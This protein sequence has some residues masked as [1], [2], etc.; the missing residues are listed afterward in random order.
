MAFFKNSFRFWFLLHICFFSLSGK[1][2]DM[3]KDVA[4]DNARRAVATLDYI[5]G[6]YYEAVA[7]E[8]GKII[9]D[10]EYQEMIR[11]ISIVQKYVKSLGI[12]EEEPLK[13]YL[14]ELN[15]FILNKAPPPGV[16]NLARDA[17]QE[18]IKIFSIPT[19]PVQ[20]PDIQLGKRLYGQACASCHGLDG[21]AE[22]PSSK[23][24]DP[25]P[26]V[27]A[28]V[29]T[30]NNLS[31][32]K[33]FNTVTF[34]I[35]GTAMAAFPMFSESERWAIASY[36]FTFRPDLPPATDDLASP[37]I[38]WQIAMRLTDGEILKRLKRLGL[39][40]EKTLHEL[41]QVR[42]LQ[43]APARALKLV[44]EGKVGFISAQ[45][46]V[47][48]ALGEFQVSLEKLD[49][50]KSKDAFDTATKAYM[51]GIKPSKEIL[52]A[53]GH[54]RLVSQMERS[55]FNFRSSLHKPIVGKND[56]GERVSQLL[57]NARKIISSSR[58][59]SSIN[60]FKG[61]FFFLICST[62]IAIVLFSVLFSILT[63]SKTKNSRIFRFCLKGLISSVILS[64]VVGVFFQDP[65]MELFHK[66]L[67]GW[68]LITFSIV[69]L[70]IAYLVASS[71]TAQR[72]NQSFVSRMKLYRR[73]DLLAFTSVVFLVTFHE[74]SKAIFFLQ[75]WK[76]QIIKQDLWILLGSFGAIAV[77]LTVGWGTFLLLKK[78]PQRLSL[79]IQ[80]L[81]LYILVLI[82]L[83]QGIHVLQ[84][85]DLIS[86][87]PMMYSSVE[88]LSVQTLFL[89]ILVF[90]LAR[91]KWGHRSSAKDG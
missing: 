4:S 70:Y 66:G 3:V 56:L 38:P 28:D 5:A 6:D 86:Y 24:L 60:V 85:V 43:Y 14:I 33:A 27:F 74:I 19:H 39:S 29:V 51:Y 46:A 64:A 90:T 76:Q 35:G 54:N 68:I 18:I 11:F 58:R 30:L 57:V 32:F 7:Q 79:G 65:L 49:Q 17:K 37:Y 61:T 10:L 15:K 44:E 22:T 41:S 23:Q 25:P 55:F 83:S 80:S 48:I 88:I 42:H 78:L 20:I 2:Q 8:G 89:A 81:M 52:L 12:E 9:H 69:L 16:E 72:D 50:K 40:L 13:G 75:I 47:E 1:A 67:G 82:F 63:Q 73:E 87:R 62:L 21:K 45:D 71:W 91:G 84:G 26:R 59:I 77:L 34:G 53:L 36:T 31:P